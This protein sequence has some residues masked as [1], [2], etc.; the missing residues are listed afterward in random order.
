[1]C[2]T[3]RCGRRVSKPSESPLIL[4]SVTMHYHCIRD[5]QPPH[6][7]KTCHGVRTEFRSVVEPGT[8]RGPG[9]RPRLPTNIIVVTPEVSHAPMSSLK[10]AARLQEQ[11]LHVRH[12]PVSPR[13]R[14]V[15]VISP[16]RR[17]V[18]AT[19]N[20]NSDLRARQMAIEVSRAS[21]TSSRLHDAARRRLARGVCR[22]NAQA[23]V[24]PGTR[25]GTGRRPGRSR[26][27]ATYHIPRNAVDHPITDVLIEGR[28]ADEHPHACDAGGVPRACPG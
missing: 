3:S 10:D 4:I 17:R 9:R 15:A 14:D 27:S 22:T 25:R 2:Q 16:R 8:S 21:S 23:H 24:C 18:R 12:P 26:T 28:G 1:M 7:P 20:C 13:R 19:A 5:V 6:A 11:L